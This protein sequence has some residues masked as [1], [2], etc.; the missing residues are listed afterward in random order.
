MLAMPVRMF[1]SGAPACGV[2]TYNCASSIDFSFF[3]FFKNFLC[4]GYR[5]DNDSKYAID[6]NCL[7]DIETT[8]AD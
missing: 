5:E 6:K 8:N 4:T 1:V 2:Y 3:F 7:P